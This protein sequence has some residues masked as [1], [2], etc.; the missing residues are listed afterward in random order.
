MSIH[1]FKSIIE[2]L[3]VVVFVCT[4]VVIFDTG[5][6][7]EVS[8]SAW[9]DGCPKMKGLAANALRD[10]PFGNVIQPGVFVADGLALLNNLLP[11]EAFVMNITQVAG[12]SLASWLIRIEFG[13]KADVHINDI[14]QGLFKTRVG[15]ELHANEQRM[16]RMVLAEFF[17][18]F[19]GGMN[20]RDDG[21]VVQGGFGG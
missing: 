10:A 6:Q 17:A 20:I 11:V 15:L 1:V 14:G 9:V 16:P 7:I 4:G 2:E 12:V 13:D 19:A 21:R 3:G 8:A 18:I 5:R